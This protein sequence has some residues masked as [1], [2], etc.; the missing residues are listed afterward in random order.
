MNWTARTALA[1]MGWTLAC[2]AWAWG[3]K[4]VKFIVPAPP[5]GT[6]DIVARIVGQQ[7][8]TDI[9]G[10]RAGARRA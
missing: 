9:D 7:L 2:S 6:M 8:S 5:G 4:P 3:E 1:A 10:R